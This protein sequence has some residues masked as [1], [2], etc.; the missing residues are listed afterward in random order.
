MIDI[1][2][3]G[4][5]RLQNTTEFPLPDPANNYAMAIRVTA[6]TRKNNQ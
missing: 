2:K 6:A 3:K 1:R 4:V 5:K